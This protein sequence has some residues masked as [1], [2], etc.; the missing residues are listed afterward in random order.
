MT[1]TAPPLV[2]LHID[3][4]VATITLNRPEKRNALNDAMLREL[5]AAVDRVEADADVR[6]V[7][8]RGEGG[9]FCS[10][11]DLGEKLAEQGTAGAV[12][13]TLLLEAFERLE[14]HP[15]PIIAVLQGTSLAG[16]WE[17]GLHCDI[18]FAAPS[19]RFGM[20]LVKLGLVVPY[21]A[22]SRL[23]HLAGAAA[24][25]DLLLS[26]ALI[27]GVRAHQLGLVSHLVEEEALATA[28]RD[29]ATRLAALAPLSLR[30]TKRILA[31]VIRTPEPAEYEA[32]DRARRQVTASEDTAEGLRAF[33]ERRP[34]RFAGR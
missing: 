21:P 16:G 29:Y 19:S 5:L 25:T 33:L 6:V 32:F 18:R 13:F 11:V 4:Q 26:G 14:R 12:E 1:D 2:Q 22:A 3:G 31:H 15:N 28:A 20:P 24:A 34:A 10:G 8:L 23:V 7:L 9:S 30:E 17:L 27:D